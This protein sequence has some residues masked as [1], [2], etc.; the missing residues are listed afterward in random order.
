MSEYI[1]I[2]PEE[3]TWKQD[4]VNGRL[5]MICPRTGDELFVI[6]TGN[7]SR[8]QLVHAYLA[9]LHTGKRR[10]AIKRAKELRALLEI[11]Q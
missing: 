4:P 8:Q 7:D 3:Y 5:A 9:G 6:N 1:G 10:G 2:T 11:G